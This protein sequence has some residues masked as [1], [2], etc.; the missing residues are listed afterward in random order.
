M[1]IPLPPLAEQCR[2]LAK[3]DKMMALCSQLESQLSDASTISH[4]LLEATINEIP[5]GGRRLSE[6]GS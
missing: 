6:V 4:Q 1:P 3:L 2:L 5:T